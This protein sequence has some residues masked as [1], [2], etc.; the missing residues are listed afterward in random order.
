MINPLDVFQPGWREDGLK[1]WQKAFGFLEN[2]QFSSFPDKIG[3][4]KSIIL[5]SAE[6]LEKYL[7]ISS[8]NPK[9]YQEFV[10]NFL[11]ERLGASNKFFLE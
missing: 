8:K 6:V 9:D 5:A 10:E 4:R 7:T 11:K 2:Y 3:K 1:N